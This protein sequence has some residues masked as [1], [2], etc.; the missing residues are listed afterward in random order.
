MELIPPAA[1]KKIPDRGNKCAELQWRAQSILP[2][3]GCQVKSLLKFLSGIITLQL[4]AALSHFIMV[5]N[6]DSFHFKM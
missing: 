4:I 5:K 1:I 6:D 3:I 2:S